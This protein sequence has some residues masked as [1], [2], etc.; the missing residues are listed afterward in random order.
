M[1]SPST[2]TSAPRACSPAAIPAIRSDS[3]WRSSPA[4]LIRCVPR[5]W[6]R[7]G[8][9]P[10]SRRSR[11]R[12]RPGRAR[13]L[14]MAAA[15]GQVGDR[16]ADVGGARAAPV[17]MSPVAP[18]ARSSISAPIAPQEV[19]DRAARGID[20]DIVERQLGVG[21]VAPATSQKAAAETSPGTRSSTACTRP[22]P[23]R[24]TDDPAGGPDPSRRTSMPRARSMRSVWS[25]VAT[26]SRTV[27]PSV[28]PQPGQQ[29]RRLDLSARH[30]RRDIDRPERG[31]ADHGEWR[32]GVVAAGVNHGAH[33]AQWADDTGHRTAAQRRRR[34]R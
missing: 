16:L 11:R 9:G 15:D 31:M 10:G 25:R 4:P 33:G 30:R 23:S 14:Q 18:T 5:A 34:R 17:A 32:E 8:T 21:M 1:S 13:C 19:D 20:A 27:G 12:R 2:S 3:L 6:P 7:R 28:G 22:P 29:D 24:L 26:D